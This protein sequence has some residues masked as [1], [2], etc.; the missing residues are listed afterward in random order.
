MRRFRIGER[1]YAYDYANP[2]GGFYA[3]YVAV[4]ANHAGRVPR[5]LD[6]LHAGAA[7]TTGSTALQ[8]IDDS[9]RLRGERHTHLRRVRCGGDTRRAVCKAPASPRVGDS[10]RP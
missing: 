9:L 10:F 4:D 6:L 7:V 2:K 1:V 3:E 8:G 5:G